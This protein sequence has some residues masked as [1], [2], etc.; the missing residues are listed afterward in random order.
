MRVRVRVGVCTS[1]CHGACVHVRVWGWSVGVCVCVCVCYVHVCGCACATCVCVMWCS[2]PGPHRP[3]S[4]RNAPRAEWVRPED[5]EASPPYPHPH[6][7]THIHTHPVGP[8]PRAVHTTRCTPQLH[9]SRTWE[10]GLALVVVQV[11]VVV[12]R[13]V[14]SLVGMPLFGTPWSGRGA[15]QSDGRG[16]PGGSV[17]TRVVGPWRWT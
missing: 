11:V 5:G 9:H 13:A 3:S 2:A 14:S 8:G 1:V 4:S 7:C 17:G 10:H 6:T 15:F 16:R 12:G